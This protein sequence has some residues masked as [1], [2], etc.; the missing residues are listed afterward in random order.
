[1]EAYRSAVTFARSLD[2]ARVAV[3][4]EEY[5][6]SGSNAT[7]RTFRDWRPVDQEGRVKETHRRDEEEDSAPVKKT[8]RGRGRGASAAGGGTRRRGQA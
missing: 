1:M 4:R 7:R 6:E 3:T 2:F 5:L 8:G